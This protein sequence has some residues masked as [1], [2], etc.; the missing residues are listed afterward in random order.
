MTMPSLGPARRFVRDLAPKP[1]RRQ[2]A[3]TWSMTKPGGPH[4]RPWP[5][6][7]RVWLA[8]RACRGDRREAFGG[9]GPSWWGAFVGGD[10]LVQAMTVGS[11]DESAGQ[12]P[13]PPH[14]SALEPASASASM[15]T[16]H[17]AEMSRLLR[18]ANT[19]V[20]PPLVPIRPCTVWSA[21]SISRSM[22][23]Y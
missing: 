4:G 9:L 1:S 5:V 18:A 3:C 15:T 8:Q 21:G 20:A 23:C 14:P 6:R 11:H 10:L 22:R 12:L 7:Q 16:T 19:G 13:R 2:A 17:D